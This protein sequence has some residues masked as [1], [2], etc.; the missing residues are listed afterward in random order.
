MVGYWWLINR[1]FSVF[2]VS[3]QLKTLSIDTSGSDDFVDM[4]GSVANP[5]AWGLRQ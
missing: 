3:R 4:G 5:P 1:E 2:G